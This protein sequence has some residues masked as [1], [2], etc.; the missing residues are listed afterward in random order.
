MFKVLLMT[1]FTLGMVN[2]RYTVCKYGHMIYTR[3]CI[4]NLKAT[5]GT[6]A[7]EY[8]LIEPIACIGLAHNT[9]F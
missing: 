1:A 4:S 2:N 8:T 5:S 3:K 6:V 9:I 7:N